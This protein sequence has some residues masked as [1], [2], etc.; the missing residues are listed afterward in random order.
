MNR[1]LS[2]LITIF[3]SSFAWAGQ[4]RLDLVLDP[5]MHNAAIR[6]MAFDDASG[7][8]YTASEDGTVKV[9]S[10]SDGSLYKT[11]HLPAYKNR[12][13]KLFALD[14]HSASNLIA[15]AGSTTPDFRH[16][17]IYVFDRKSGRL[18]KTVPGLS[19][20]ITALRFSADGRFLAAGMTGG[21]G[22][23]VFS[24][25]SWDVVLRDSD[26]KGDVYA[27]DFAPSSTLASASFDGYIRQYNKSFKL[28]GK[29]QPQGG[30]RPYSVRYSPTGA[31]I[32]VGFQDSPNIEVLSAGDLSTQYLPDVRKVNNG[33]LSEVAWSRDGVFLY[34]GGSFD[35]GQG[36][37]IIRW[38]EAGKG[39]R[40]ASRAGTNTISRI[41]TTP[42]GSMLFATLDP[43]FGS[44][45]AKGKARYAQRA[46]AVD[47]RESQGSIRFSKTDKQLLLPQAPRAQ[48]YWLFD[49]D[50]LTLQ[51]SGG[52][53]THW[54]QPVTGQ[55]DVS[56]RYP[57]NGQGLQI[58]GKSVDLA[59]GERVHSHVINAP[60]G[61]VLVGADWS[62]RYYKPDGTKVW[63]RATPG[64]AWAVNLT[65]DARFAIGA[66]SDGTVRWYDIHTGRERLALYIDKRDQS[67]V[68]WTPEGFFNASPGAESYIGWKMTQSFDNKPDFFAI[69]RF[70]QQYYDHDLLAKV[71]FDGGALTLQAPKNDKPQPE[72][73][74][75]TKPAIQSGIQTA[76][77]PPPKPAT[78]TLPPVVTIL[79]HGPS[80][81]FQSENIRL[82]YEVTDKP[83]NKL[84]DVRV[85]LDGRPV[86]KGRGLVRAKKTKSNVK[87]LDVTLPKRDVT[88]TVIAEG[89]HSVS[90]P[91][92]VHF[93]WS[94]TKSAGMDLLKPKLYVL[95]IGISNYNDTDIKLAFASK[96]ARDFANI[97]KKQQ[98][99]LYRSVE[100]K[101]IPDAT[102]DQMLDGLSW[103]Q[104][105]VT[106]RDVAMLFLAGHGVNDRNGEYYFLPAN[107]DIERIKTTGVTY[108]AIKQTITNLPGKSVFFVDTCHSGN[109]MGSTTRRGVADVNGVVMDL[110]S[111]ENGVVVF[112]SSTG[113]QYSLENP[114][115]HNG[116][117]T[118]ALVEG[119]SG[120]A[121]LFNNNRITINTLDAYIANRVKEL[122][123]NKQTPTTSK[124]A[125]IQDFPIAVDLR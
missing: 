109:V 30:S 49:L 44:Y 10:G 71:L 41:L 37:V 70:R 45:D 6:D 26:Y 95:A 19:D 42:D 91:A 82:V 120:K 51:E 21:K 56:V 11:L 118:K 63:A 93:A 52:G 24:T 35:A 98:G 4:D 73:K 110:T 97:I 92:T 28:I 125:T 58:N 65:N 121:D 20:T 119:L 84:K 116:A 8:V 104:D 81:T 86:S 100:V 69:N 61:Y 23:V 60:S 55:A 108:H 2:A 107:T 59:K 57:A 90:E 102:R 46:S 77:Q 17:Y 75:A 105:E 78:Q 31:L 32:A 40:T 114:S 39:R 101:L 18:K 9:W 74:P 122:T 103:L 29:Q 5:P 96:D 88:L 34:A 79:S 111:A 106:A 13:A 64:T 66:F 89:E 54:T 76:T 16:F 67:W 62:L 50:Q 3:L 72:V 83:D 33:N 68:A 25:K 43:S 85:L 80:E 123:H 94:G 1:V 112:A 47:F 99:T 38:A 124:P 117:F 87:T 53:D 113:K 12:Q 48:Q 15:V 7:V 14:I 36:T 22:I 115:W 27:L